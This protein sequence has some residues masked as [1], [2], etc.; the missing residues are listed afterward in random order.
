MARTTQPRSEPELKPYPISCLQ[1]LKEVYHECAASTA[2]AQILHYEIA[3]PKK[4]Q[5]SEVKRMKAVIDVD[6][7]KAIVDTETDQIVVSLREFSHA[8][9]EQDNTGTDLMA[10]VTKNGR[11]VYYLHHWTTCDDEENIIKAITKDE[12]L[13]LLMQNYRI[14][15][16]SELARAAKYGLE[17]HETA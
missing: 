16:E 11:T 17:V 4:K 6:V 14:Y 15:T 10:H 5:L 8:C 2:R 3:L 7:K 12:A 1:N 9:D 13:S